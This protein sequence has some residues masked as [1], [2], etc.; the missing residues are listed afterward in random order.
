MNVFFKDEILAFFFLGDYQSDH[1]CCDDALNLENKGVFKQ[2]LESII[3]LEM[4]NS[5]HVC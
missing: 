3:G 5:R 1:S 4:N 2:S